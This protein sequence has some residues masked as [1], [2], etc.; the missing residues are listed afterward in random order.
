[1][2]PLNAPDAIARA[3]ELRKS[4]RAERDVLDE[5]RRYWTGRQALP[6]VIP[7]NAAGEVLRMARMSR[8]NICGLVVESLSQSLFVEGFRAKNDNDNTA[9][10]DVWQKNK[11]DAKQTG[12]HRAALAYGTGYALV[13]PGKPVP[14]IRGL[15][16]RL[17]HAVYGDDPDWPV[18]ALETRGGGEF[19]LYDSEAIYRL[20]TPAGKDDELEHLETLEYE[21]A[22]GVTPIVRFK[23]TDDLDID[24]DVEDAG[25]VDLGIIDESA[26][27][28][29]VIPA[30]FGTYPL[31]AAG[32][33]APIMAVQ[34]QIDVITFNLL[35]AQ[36]FSA[37]RQRFI[38]GWTG[39]EEQTLAATASKLW[40]FDDPDTKVGDLSETQ[41]DGMI[42]AREASLR[43][44]ASLTQTPAH[45]LIGELVNMSA[46]ALAAAEAGRDRKV[47]DR[48]TLFGEAH[49]QMLA[50]AGE[51][52]G[53]NVPDDAQT[54]WRDTSARSFSAVVDALVKLAEGLGIPASELWERIPGVTQSDVERWKVQAQGSDAMQQLTRLLEGQA[55]GGTPPG[56]PAPPQL[57]APTPPNTLP[58]GG[59]NI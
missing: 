23:D 30:V 12:I 46:E 25:F 20:K 51:L 50:L 41:L 8:V 24:L 43:H 2:A 56:P 21:K 9:I 32:Q 42:R 35:V 38:M 13:T 45:E 18:W 39:S 33:I 5:V 3:Q 29:L 27:T 37:F 15:S 1:M 47:A 40:T 49:E 10:W 28:G 36:H 52:G 11:M 55:G 16:P 48:Q 17:L 34:D 58:A 54:V 57:P 44:A 31:L 19:R 26:T 59:Q 14:V 7:K 22:P 6:R 4:A 53:I